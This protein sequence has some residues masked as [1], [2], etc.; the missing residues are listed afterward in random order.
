MSVAAGLPSTQEIVDALKEKILDGGH[1]SKN[2][3]LPKVSQEFVN[4]YSRTDLLKFVRELFISKSNE[5]D[6]SS[7][8]LLR[9]IQPKIKDIITTNWDQLIEDSLG[10][11]NYEPIFEPSLI[12]R[13]SDYKT[14]LFKIHGDI[15]RDFIIT[16]NDYIEYEY[17][18]KPII[19]KLT[20]LFAERVIVFIGYSTDDPNFLNIYKKIRNE[21][22]EK[23][24]LKRYFVTRKLDELKYAKLLE[25]GFVPIESEIL[26]FLIALVKEQNQSIPKYPLKSPKTVPTLLPSDHNPFKIFRAEDIE[27]VDWINKT[28]VKPISYSTIV[29][30]GNV[31]I[32]GHRGSG[33]SMILQYMDFLTLGIRDEIISYIGFYLKLQ[34]S[35]IETVYRREES[36][37]EWK[38][39]FFHYFNLL[40]GE[41]IF[42]SILK[43]Q[44]KGL[45]EIN[46]EKRMVERII[47]MHFY[48]L[49]INY[50]M[51]NLQ[52]LT[53]L[54]IRERNR[55]MKY[56]RPRESRLTAHFIYD[57]LN[58]VQDHIPIYKDKFFYLLI[59]EYERLSDNQQL[60]INSY[61][62]DRGAALRYKVSF[63]IAVKTFGINYTTIEGDIMDIGDDFSWVPL[64]RLPDREK[65]NFIEHLKDIGL[66]RLKVYGY[67][68]TDLSELFPSDNLG[69]GNEDYSGINNIM[70][71]SSFLV[72]DYLEL[73]KDMLYHTFP[74]IMYEKR[75][76]LPPVPTV[77]Q[78]FV[79]KVHSNILYSTKIDEIPGKFNDIERKDISRLLID[80][81]GLIFQRILE[82]SISKEKRTV[83]SFQLRNESKLSDISS[84]AL[85]DCRAIG[86]LQVPYFRRVPQNYSRHA[87]HRM[88]E[89][90]RLLCPRFKLSLSKRWP[91]E[92][93]AEIF[94]NIFNEESNA[95][96]DITQYYLGN[97]MLELIIEEIKIKDEY[98]EIIEIYNKLNCLDGSIKELFNDALIPKWIKAIDGWSTEYK[99]KTIIC[100]NDVEKKYITLFIEI[101][102]G[103]IHIPD[104]L[105]NY[106]IDIENLIRTK[107][108]LDE[109]IE[110]YS[111]DFKSLNWLKLKQKIW[112]A[113][114][115]NE[116]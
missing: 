98:S 13:Y 67:E 1:S 95:I 40:L 39:F 33:K 60:V 70:I 89:F 41:S 59:D 66:T 111:M 88:Y 38:E 93:D 57:L 68:N 19:N 77:D 113:I 65:N 28:F 18:W 23:F 2:Q 6:L 74:W 47:F 94:N 27:N 85:V 92:L 78:N 10:K 43:Q 56:P 9:K 96:N 4:L 30:P 106:S 82:G 31:I 69:Y 29:S 26:D 101:G 50:E 104:E 54:F 116:S 36:K 90:H 17:N 46:D 48:D 102:A 83:S 58:T 72:R 22:G 14:N 108:V 3:D 103:E 76:Y 37:E 24:L 109:I 81:L 8:E 12:A 80:S 112:E 73:L 64:D 49:D 105:E 55:S 53:D 71:L 7:Y 21:V 114:F 79:I 91:R 100:K 63:K 34:N 11:T 25:R 99:R 44:E 97:I 61:I 107:K 115:A 32:E 110:K 42:L 20:S 51:N 45:I 52:N 35:Y 62:T 87:P 5:V 16:E 86:V 75:N 15:D 84:I